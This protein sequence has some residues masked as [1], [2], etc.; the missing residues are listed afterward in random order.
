MS[1][2]PESEFD[3]VARPTDGVPRELIP[4]YSATIHWFPEDGC[5][6]ATCPELLELFGNEARSTGESLAEAADELTGV[7]EGLAA[8]R[9]RSRRR[10]PREDTFRVFSG[11]LTL[12]MPVWLHE[13]V[14]A[15]ARRDRVSINTWL[16]SRLAEA[17]GRLP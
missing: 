4:A 3:T 11:S 10:L 8:R 12:R 17:A 7:V 9:I 13:R 5:W 16:V 15:E 6:V 1:R 2:I 14:A